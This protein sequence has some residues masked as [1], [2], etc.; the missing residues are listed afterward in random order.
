M[1]LSAVSYTRAC[2]DW[3]RSLPHI[4]ASI[5]GGAHLVQHRRRELLAA[6]LGAAH[7]Q[8]DV[9][10][11]VG[12]AQVG[13]VQAIRQK[14]A[15]SITDVAKLAQDGLRKD[16]R[17]V[18][19][20]S[21]PCWQCQHHPELAALRAVTAKAKHCKRYAN[22]LHD[23]GAG[24]Q[25]RRAALRAEHAFKRTSSATVSPA[26]SSAFAKPTSSP[27][28]RAESATPIACEST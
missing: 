21:V 26:A 18:G 5:A 10:Q 3:H 25:D 1:M 22:H 7:A 28:A 8:Q 12:D 15:V 13:G 24:M 20:V 6:V 27:A 11:V 9:D 14:Q 23:S 2:C 19:S 4:Y 17:E 16:T